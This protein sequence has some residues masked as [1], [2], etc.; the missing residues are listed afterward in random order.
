MLTFYV[1]IH[2]DLTGCIREEVFKI[3]SEQ[4]IYPIQR[5]AS[6]ARLC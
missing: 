4:R 2:D 6:W 5:L 1:A 3:A